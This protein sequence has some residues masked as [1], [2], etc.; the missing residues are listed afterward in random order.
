V[1]DTENLY[2]VLFV[3]SCTRLVAEPWDTVIDAA[4]ME[5]AFMGSENVTTNLH[6]VWGA[7]SVPTSQIAGTS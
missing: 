4:E 5:D 7:D 2:L 6:W 3:D 1:T